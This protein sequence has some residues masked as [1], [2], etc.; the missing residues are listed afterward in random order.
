MAITLTVTTI[1]SAG[2]RWQSSTPLSSD[3]SSGIDETEPWWSMEFSSDG[4]S[5]VA[6]TAPPDQL[7]YQLR[8][9]VGREV[10]TVVAT[11]RW[12]A[13]AARGETVVGDGY[14]PPFTPGGSTG[15]SA[16]LA[17]AQRR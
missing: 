9:E 17:K 15:S 3:M 12:L 16:A 4:V 8:A 11:R 6:F 13:G 7:E 5:P 10:A 14:R 2:H 1:D